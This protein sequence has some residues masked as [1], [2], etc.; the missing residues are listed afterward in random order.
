MPSP[1][2]FDDKP[3]EET[4]FRSYSRSS[5]DFLNRITDPKHVP[6]RD[7]L[8]DWFS[9]YPEEERNDLSARFRSSKEAAHVGA[10]FELLV[11]ELHIKLG[12]EV[13]AHFAPSQAGPRTPDFFVTDPV[14]GSS[15]VEATVVT[16]KSKKRQAA[17]ARLD[18]I[19]GTLNRLIE[20]PNFWLSMERRGLP[21]APANAKQVAQEIN[22]NL[23]KLAQADETDLTTERDSDSFPIWSFDLEGCVLSFRPF[24]KGD[25]ARGRSSMRPIALQSGEFETV[26]HRGPIRKAIVRKANRYGRLG[27]PF[28]VALNCIEMVDGIDIMEALFGQEQFHIP[29]G[30]DRELTA[31]DIGFSRKPDGAWTNPIGPRYSRVSA[32]LVATHLLP[33][34]ISEVVI[35]LYHNP[36]AELEYSSVLTR[37]NQARLHN[38]AMRKVEGD[39]LAH[40][41]ELDRYWQ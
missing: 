10:F 25:F 18:D 1:S 11:H 19:V 28:V 32:V 29:V 6:L 38:G 21:K 8:D 16:G 4:I 9:R 41:L 37:L 14:T 24:P 27:L 31:K 39:S 13:H 15:Y 5:F 34:S 22:R 40:V 23:A 12:A 26:D 2:L 7:M 17:E 20:S 33:W 3:P 35:R 30:L 36:W